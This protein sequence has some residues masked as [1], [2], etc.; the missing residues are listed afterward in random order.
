MNSQFWPG[1]KHIN[2]HNIPAS[3]FFFSSYIFITLLVFA[4]VLFPL[5][6]SGVSVSIFVFSCKSS[7]EVRYFHSSETLLSKY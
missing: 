3:F 7:M 4:S 1:K 5:Y 6:S 2:V